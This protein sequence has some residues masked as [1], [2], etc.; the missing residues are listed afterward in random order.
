MK[1]R[2]TQSQADCNNVQNCLATDNLFQCLG[3]VCLVSGYSAKSEK[4]FARKEE[5]SEVARQVTENIFTEDI[6]R[7]AQWRE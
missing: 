1:E 4:R 6:V 5:S 7:F 2:A 3:H